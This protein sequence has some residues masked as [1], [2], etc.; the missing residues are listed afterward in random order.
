MHNSFPGKALAIGILLM[1]VQLP[2]A[3]FYTE[4]IQSGRIRVKATTEGRSR[5]VGVFVSRCSERIDKLLGLS[6]Q[7]QKTLTVQEAISGDEE[8]EEEKSN[9]LRV[10]FRPDMNN[11][12]VVH[13]IVYALIMRREMELPKEEG[14]EEPPPLLWNKK[15]ETPAANWLAAGVTHRILVE[16]MGGVGLMSKDYEI[17]RNQYSLREFP[18]VDMLV[19]GGI[20]VEFRPLF[21]LFMLHA[22]LLLLSLETLRRGQ[23]E[24]FVSMLRGERSGRDPLVVFDEL[25]GKFYPEGKGRQEFYE[26]RVSI[27]SLQRHRGGGA[28]MIA[29]RVAELE[30]VPLVGG[31]G[32][33]A[34][35]RVRLEEIPKLL[36]DYKADTRAFMRLEQRFKDLQMDAPYLLRD[37]LGRYVEALQLLREGK[38]RRFEKEFK[39]ARE[40]F[41]KALTKQRELDAYLDEYERSSTSVN[42]RL[43][44]FIEII[45]RYQRIADSLYPEEL[46]PK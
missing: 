1:A 4:V 43:D 38:L 24:L 37:S 16:E 42:A 31:S 11:V 22:D 28:E 39:K 25:F 2:A 18:G 45:Q 15:R 6:G 44:D 36:E 12:E 17:A 10:R 13:S 29:E 40:A 20:D 27:I 35:K 3:T 8:E 5:A 7:P 26:H 32:P 46:F 9:P 14:E 30:T 23:P 33:D 34:L 41:L 21:E 19:G